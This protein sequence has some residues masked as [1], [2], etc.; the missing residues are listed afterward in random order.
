MF[1]P[2]HRSPLSGSARWWPD[3]AATRAFPIGRLLYLTM[4]LF[5]GL[6]LAAWPVQARYCPPRDRGLSPAVPTLEDMFNPNPS[7]ADIE[8]PMPC[9]GKLI[10]RHVCV[11]ASGYFGDLQLDLG[12]KDCGRPKQG[13]MEGKRK[14][15]LSGPFTLQDLPEPWRIK[16]TELAK[17]GEG[18]CPSPNDMTTTGFYYFIGKYEISNFQW[19]AIMEGRC[20]GSDTPF[21]AEDP[22]PKTEISWFE[23]IDFTR[24]YTEWLLKNSPE[25]LP[26][27]SAGRFGYLRLPTE[28]EW[29]YAARGGHL[30]TESQMNREEFFPL[31]GRT[32][33]EYA[34]FTEPEAAKPP[35]KLA[36]IGSRCSN[37]LGLFDT[38]GNA[39][40]MVMDPFRFSVGSR[41]H[42]TTGGFVVK[43]G[44]YR[45]GKVEI[46]PGRR[47]EVPFFLKDGAFRSTD[48][49][50][51]IVLSAIVT[52]VDRKEVLDHEWVKAGIGS[53]Q[54]Q[55]GPR[56]SG[57]MFE[58][59]QGKDPIS[60]IDRLLAA[61]SDEME[62]KTSISL[63]RSSSR[64]VTCS[65][66]GKRKRLRASSRVP[67]LLR[68]L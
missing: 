57:L 66:N 30:V 39:A 43:G 44:S 51:R 65:L 34:V 10:L 61:S 37:P 1:S 52:P 67:F 17:M 11:P 40:E 59:E 8:L 28:V 18:R 29:E 41:L 27:F 35:E 55:P 22:R 13:F 20:P 33:G 60:E 68:N 15:A 64:R 63:G 56:P 21:T 4:A 45:K 49:G 3:E 54:S 42:G 2:I 50:F 7:K 19:K 24:R 58:I 9:E 31:H 5:I 6:A 46:M 53:R 23:A 36:W 32:H 38:A 12:C 47:E 16:L 62:K 48:L 14:A 25:S 26:R